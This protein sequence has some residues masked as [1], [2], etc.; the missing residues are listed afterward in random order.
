MQRTIFFLLSVCFSLICT[1]QLDKSILIYDS[2]FEQKNFESL[3]STSALELLISI[4]PNMDEARYNEIKLEIKEIIDKLERKKLMNIHPKNQAKLMQF[5]LH[6]K[7][8]K[9]YKSVSPFHRIF[10][11]GQY[12]CVSSTALFAIICDHFGIPYT[13]KEQPDHVYLMM[14][15]ESH[16]VEVQTTAAR[17][18]V[19]MERQ[20]NVEKS[21][22]TLVELGYVNESDVKRKGV[23]RAFNDYFYK[24][25]NITLKQL[26]GDQYAN[27]AIV[28]MEK[29]D[30]LRSISSITKACAI[31]PSHRIQFIKK[32]ILDTYIHY[33]SFKGIDDLAYL[34]EYCNLEVASKSNIHY[35]F[36]DFV[37]KNLV[38]FENKKHLDSCY[39]YLMNNIVI[40]ENA[41]VITEYYYY[42][43]S[44]YYDGARNSKLALQYI[45]KTIEVNP[46]NNFAVGYASKIIAGEVYDFD[47]DDYYDKMSEEEYDALEDESTEGQLRLEI[48]DKHIKTY[49]TLGETSV[50]KT[51]YYYIYAETSMEAFD[52]YDDE[53]T[54]LE[55]LE[56]AKTQATSIDDP[57]L[58]NVEMTGWMY[59]AAGAYYYRENQLEKA[60]I[61][62]NEGLKI[63]PDHPRLLAKEKIIKNAMK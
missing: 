41:K 6:G 4:D 58:I 35:K 50:I 48:L 25:I 20:L 37:H 59:S 63:A 62:I 5:L 22:K 33:K 2:E 39:S 10:L 43:L 30:T 16:R 9:Y 54:G 8:L 29:K 38:V 31:Y 14:Y 47:I 3:E 45:L 52:D 28:Y 53:K 13:I 57:E 60:L 24:D 11:D 61:F 49:P 51:L 40:E 17:T 34:K 7:K 18:G 56:K 44:E 19:S 46:K 26:A 27:E 42:G 15:P 36:Y 21:M 32:G 12:N 55:F 23:E 1:A